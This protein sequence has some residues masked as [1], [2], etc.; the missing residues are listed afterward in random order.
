M[1]QAPATKNWF[2]FNKGINSEQ[3]EINM[4]DGFSTDEANYELL[5]DG[6]RRRRRRLAQEA[7]GGTVTLSSSFS[8][9][10]GVAQSYVWRNAGGDTTTHFIVHKVGS[11][12]YFTPDSDGGSASP[13][14]EVFNLNDYRVSGN[15]TSN[16]TVPCD[17]SQGR[18]VLF[19][20]TENNFPLW[21]RYDKA[22][23]TF[24]SDVIK[25]QIRDYQDIEDAVPLDT[26]VPSGR[27]G[28]ATAAQLASDF[29]D[30]R[31]NL[32]NRG[33][34]DDLIIQYENNVTGTARYPAKVHSP[35]QAH[36]L[37]A[38]ESTGTAVDK[39]GKYTFDADYL[40][41]HPATGSSA[42]KGSMLLSVFND[43]LGF[44]EV[45]VDGTSTEVEYTG[46][47]ATYAAGP[48]ETLTATDIVYSD[49][50]TGTWTVTISETGHSLSINDEVRWIYAPNIVVVLGT[51]Q[52]TV[53]SCPEFV[54]VTATNANDW[55]FEVSGNG[56]DFSASTYLLG[57]RYSGLSYQAKRYGYTP[58][59]RSSGTG[60]TTVGPK[61][62]E[63]HG[64]RLFYA[65]LADT[66]W[67]DYVFFSQV[68]QKE[69]NYSRCHTENDPTGWNFNA[70]QITD[71]GFLVLP[72]IGNV[73][74][75]LSLQES[76]LLFT[77]QGVWEIRG[78]GTFF[79]PT[80]YIVRKITDAE[81]GSPYS[82]IKVEGT[83]VYTGPKGVYN[84]APDQYTRQLEA[85]NI[86][87]DRIREKWNAIT[88][89]YEPYVKTVYDDANK[90]LYFLQPGSANISTTLVSSD[91]AIGQY[92]VIWV[93]DLRVGAWYK[94]EFNAN[95]NTNA[96][97]G[98]FAITG[99]D[100]SQSNKKLKFLVQKSSTTFIVCDFSESS[101]T[102][103]QD[104]DGNTVQSFV[105]TAYDNIGNFSQR[106]QA[107]IVTV[108]QK[109]TETG[110][111][112]SGGGWA[113]NNPSSTTMTA[114]WD[115]TDDSVTGKV[116]S[117]NEVYRHT[118]G[119]VPSGADDVDGYPV[120]VTRNKVRGRGR[121]LQL[122]FAASTDASGEDSHIL[123]FTIDYK[124]S[125][126]K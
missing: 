122:K 85:R 7:S 60:P 14:S 5:T 32:L 36:K 39:T 13:R 84:I 125:R 23:D 66:E 50:G 47:A 18:G 3:S 107:P 19:I 68:V 55:S 104:F 111:T 27:S 35:I 11:Y 59:A 16:A 53:F 99:Q 101:G 26:Q 21:I 114:Y 28:S 126:R 73:I 58:V 6:S 9:A 56:L 100:D 24:E 83:I 44:K 121:A 4:E 22:A 113:P 74:K 90:R 15:T 70:P 54:T 37:L 57:Q 46:G 17:F 1:P 78:K 25:I 89:T 41:A 10:S 64:G 116:G 40:D 92:S 72:D 76:L 102:G 69:R 20:T 105:L 30:H 110:Y 31:Y 86:S 65:G 2:Q 42:P 52:N 43:T 108:Y 63:F 91:A 118:R 82:P 120:V 67:A 117:S 95:S 88:N 51:W 103:Y 112:A 109:R 34:N 123:G 29:P 98:A 38:D 93:F 61:A 119:F 75:M 97:I 48:P 80:D 62:V 106:R 45:T 8:A 115:W 87:D 96:I 79:D 71:G 33:W 81:C 94:Y 77:D 12:I 124:V 49:P